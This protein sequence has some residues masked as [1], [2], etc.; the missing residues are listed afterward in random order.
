MKVCVERNCPVLTTGRRCR[1]HAREHGHA[2]GSRQARGYDTAYDHERARWAPLVRQGLTNCHAETCLEQ[3]RRISGAAPWDLGHSVDRS[4][5]TG[6]EHQRCN[7][8]AGG[9]AAHL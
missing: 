3:S 7:R 6:P 9:R 5:V 2:R 1:T 8:S 4:R